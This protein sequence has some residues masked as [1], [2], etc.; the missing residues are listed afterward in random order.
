MDWLIVLGGAVAVFGIISLGRFIQLRANRQMWLE[1]RV[2]ELE[3]R[4]NND[5]L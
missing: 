2:L 5:H 4:L 3:R 1:R